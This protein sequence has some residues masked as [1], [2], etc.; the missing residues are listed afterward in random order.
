MRCY[1]DINTRKSS[2]LYN[3]YLVDKTINEN[4]ENASSDQDTP[5]SIATQVKKVYSILARK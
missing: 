1:A 3:A 5:V 4:V 2:E